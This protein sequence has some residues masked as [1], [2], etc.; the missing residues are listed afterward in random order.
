MLPCGDLVR[1]M[2]LDMCVAAESATSCNRSP[3]DYDVRTEKHARTG[4]LPSFSLLAR[5]AIHPRVSDLASASLPPLAFARPRSHLAAANPNGFVR[6]RTYA[7]V[8]HCSPFANRAR[9]GEARVSGANSSVTRSSLARL[10]IR[11]PAP[12]LISPP[13]VIDRLLWAPRLDS[14]SIGLLCLELTDRTTDVEMC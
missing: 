13:E 7:V 3:P 9:R 11:R 2:R 8:S 14:L 12:P 5:S 1:S 10:L 6:V 4:S